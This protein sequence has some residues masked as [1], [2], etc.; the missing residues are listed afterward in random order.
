MPA[1]SYYSP[2]EAQGLFAEA[3]DAFD[4]GD[5][6]KARE[7]Y[8]KLIQHGQ[9]GPDVLYNLGT[10][11]L[12]SGDLGGAV[13]YL[14]RARKAGGRS[15]DIDANLAVARSRQMDQ[16]VG[17]TADEPFVDRVVDATSEGAVGWAFMILW[18]AAFGLLLL[19]R[20][21]RRGWVLGLAVVL[22]VAALPTGGLVAAHAWSSQKQLAVV[23]APTLP[24]RELP[25]DTAKVSFEIHAGL[26]VRL[27]EQ[28]G[29]FVRIQLPN[30]LEGWSPKDGLAEI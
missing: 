25:K 13:L 22:L 9:G 14:E 15:E 2:V 19:R 17:V 30:G 23:T 27:I 21:A 10:T 3:N 8:E 16:V 28:A 5:F 24:A 11:A 26:K 7:D 6:A 4:R 20:V 1:E 29:N 18:I 12:A